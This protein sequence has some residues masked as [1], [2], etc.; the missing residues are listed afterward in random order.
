M[1]P[2][3]PI[4]I[5]PNDPDPPV[6]NTMR[7]RLEVSDILQYVTLAAVVGSGIWHLREFAGKDDVEK[8]RDNVERLTSTVRDVDKSS[9]LTARDTDTIKQSQAD[10]KL[11]LRDI[12]T[13]LGEI[14]ATLGIRHGARR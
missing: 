5:D 3:V 11:E 6:Q 10:Q 13:Q 8:V 2:R 1:K 7:S 9:A 4:I 12:K 14:T